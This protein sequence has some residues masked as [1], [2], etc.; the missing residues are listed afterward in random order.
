MLVILLT[1]CVVSLGEAFVPQTPHLLHMV[2]RKIKRPTGIQCLQTRTTVSEFGETVFI[3]TLKFDFPGQFRSEVRMPD[4]D[5]VL[6]TTIQSDTDFV[7]SIAATQVVTEKRLVDHGIDILL[8][9]D[10]LR[11]TREMLKAGVD[12]DTGALRRYQDRICYVI[13]D[14]T[15]DPLAFSS[16]WIEKESL[17]PLRYLLKQGETLV[18]FRYG[19]WQKLGRGWYPTETD[20][21]LNG[22]EFTRIRVEDVRLVAGFP[23]ELFDVSGIQ[24]VPSDDAVDN[25][26]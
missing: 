11:M 16:L 6:E 20:I 10:P 13:G 15:R 5:A 8:Y 7:K 18:E 25:S 26:L 21:L 4:S 19:N 17:L 14:P 2:V 24:M 9:R 12:V 23:S 3:E 1:L 22:K